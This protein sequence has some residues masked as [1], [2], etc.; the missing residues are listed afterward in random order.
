MSTTRRITMLGAMDLYVGRLRPDKTKP[1]AKQEIFRFVQ[2][3]GAERP[4]SELSPPEIGDY[5]EQAAVSVGGLETSERF[6]EVRKFLAFAKDE[7][8]VSQNLSA[9]LRLRKTKGLGRTVGSRDGTNTQELT[10]EG[11]SQLL[12]ELEQQK[13]KR[14][15]LAEEI[16]LAAADKDV[17][18]NVPLEA[19]REQLGM[20]EA[21]ISEIEEILKV[22]VV[23][24]KKKIASKTISI[25][26]SVVVEDLGSGHKTKYTL[27][28]ATEASPLKKKISDLSPVGK[29]LLNKTTN[30]EIEVATPGGTQR[31]KVIAIS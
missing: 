30:D 12:K 22:S 28:G 18:E 9:H 31:Y 20:V 5:S 13:A 26:S 6:Q 10:K 1:E 8:L 27:V 3:F 2:W 14:S 23:I 25:G 19:A 24:D 7:G 29:A 21:R 15:P 17:R 4:I 11:H 16:Q